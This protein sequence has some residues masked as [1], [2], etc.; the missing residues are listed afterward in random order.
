MSEAKIL[1]LSV[2]AGAGHVRAAEALRRCAEL[3]FPGVETLHLDVMQYVTTAFRKIYTDWYVKFVSASPTMWRL[4]YEITDDANPRGPLQRLRRITERLNTKALLRALKDFQP[5]AVVCT[6]FL[7]AELLMHQIGRDQ[8]NVPVWVQVTDFDLHRMWVMP[9]MAGYFAGNP[10][11]AARMRQVIAPPTQIH[12]TGI[13]VM[14]EFGATS[15]QALIRQR[16]GLEPARPMVLLMGGGAGMGGLDDVARALLAIERDFQLV[17]LAGKN[18]KTLDALQPL[19]AQYPGRLIA[20][21]FTSEVHCLMACASFV[22]TKPGGLSTSECLAVGVPMILNSPIP[23]QE[24]RNADYLLEHGAAL[25][26]ADEF[27]LTWRV[28]RLLGDPEL[29]ESMRRHAAAIGRPEAARDVL[30]IVLGQRHEH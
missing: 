26:A 8:L 24:E 1:L 10:E 22:I 9:N 4:L 17:V 2:S 25:K 29:L 16:C 27:A 23:G 11:I 19:A 13:P 7:P 12:S 3:Q 21:G 15:D 28:R 5:T 20:L 18:Q 6:H 14:P 30:R